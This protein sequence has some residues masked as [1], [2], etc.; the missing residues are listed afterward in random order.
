MIALPKAMGTPH[1]HSGLGIRKIHSSGIY[2]ARVGLGLRAVFALR[3]DQA[4]L[5]RVGSHEDVR[6]YLASL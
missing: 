5:V 6:K 2:E 4:I 1:G 3:L